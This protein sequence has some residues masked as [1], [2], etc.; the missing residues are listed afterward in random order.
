[1][2]EKIT[3]IGFIGVGTMGEPMAANL[4]KAGF[5][6]T[7][8]AHRNRAPVERL[9]GQGAREA[10]TAAE[11]AGAVQAIVTCVSDDA[12]V[13]EV[14]TGP[15]GIAEGASEGLIVIDT[16][17][18]SPLTSQRLAAEVSARG[19]TLL[20]APISGG[21]N[22]AIA[23]TLAIMVGGP[24][25]AFDAVLPALEAMGKSITYVGE[26]GSALAVKL[27]NNLI[28][29]ATQVAISEALTMVAQAGVEPG[30]AHSI[31]VNATAGSRQLDGAKTSLLAGDLRPGFKLSLMRKDMG[32]ALDYGKAL[33]VPMFSTA[34][35]HQLY[36]L[37]MGM[38]KG[39]L[40]AIGVAEV[41][42]D[43]TGAKLTAE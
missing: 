3:R 24:R 9:V 21:Q 7:V 15:D 5:E 30:L 11:I 27:A 12:A 41:Y 28:V 6:V 38:G 4:L 43:A 39:D 1:M 29:A 17:T 19:I 2:E 32:L 16:S 25:E 23:G 34:L 13:E 35:S 40:T 31:L 36:T 14:L 18:I 26:N 37:A 33:G 8:M 22:G 10:Q 20:D 42:T